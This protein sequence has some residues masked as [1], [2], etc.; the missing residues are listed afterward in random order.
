MNMTPLDEYKLIIEARNF[1]YS[2]FHTWST[3]F[4]VIVGALFVAFYS[5]GDGNKEFSLLIAALGFIVSLCWYWSNKGYTY[6]WIHWAKYLMYVERTENLKADVD[7]KDSIGSNF[8]GTAGVYTTFFNGERDNN[9]TLQGD[10]TD[11]FCVKRGANVSTSKV[12]LIM[13]FI[14]SV[15]WG[16]VL[17]GLLPEEAGLKDNYCCR[18]IGSL[19][20]TWILSSLFG[21]FMPSDISNHKLGGEKTMKNT[22][23]I[24]TDIKKYIICDYG[25][26]ETGKSSTLRGVISFLESSKKAVRNKAIEYLPDGDNSCGMDEYAKYEV[27]GVKIAVCTQGD[28]DSDQAIKLKDAV[29]WGADVIVCAA[30]D[31]CEKART[32]VNNKKSF[33]DLSECKIN[34]EETKKEFNKIAK[35]IY[36]DI[37]TVE[38]V[39]MTNL[40]DYIKIWYRNF[41]ISHGDNNFSSVDVNTC[42]EMS[43]VSAR[44]I[45]ELIETLTNVTIL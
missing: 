39:Y 41:F 44:G 26:E 15:A 32:V 6:W 7:K 13:T 42:K 17:L 5:V 37:K 29:Q 22:N 33:L 20:G 36:K 23:V 14:V 18:L 27:N 28:P 45:I 12:I 30:R 11:Y 3:Y 43:R 10:C 8:E 34:D 35:D 1:H 4:S 24:K 21:S 40:K 16:F 9:G 31:D 2:K 38:N 19:F 25:G